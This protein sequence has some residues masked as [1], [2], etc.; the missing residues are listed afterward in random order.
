E[1]AEAM[2]TLLARLRAGRKSPYFGWLERPLRRARP[3]PPCR[4]NRRSSMTRSSRRLSIL[5]LGAAAMMMFAGAAAAQ[6]DAV[7]ATVNGDPVTETDLSMAIADLEDQFARL[8]EEQR[9]AAALSAVVE[10]RLMA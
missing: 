7:V 9:R 1:G 3:Q 8:P 6:D 10:I 5:S 2:S 4:P